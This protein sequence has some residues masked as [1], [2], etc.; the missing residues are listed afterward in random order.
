MV[1]GRQSAFSDAEKHDKALGYYLSET[2]T[3]D[4]ALKG[5]FTFRHVKEVRNKGRKYVLEFPQCCRGWFPICYCDWILC[6]ERSAQGG[7]RMDIN[8]LQ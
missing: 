3:I 5:K 8:D 2:T 4:R 1:G 6:K 7:Y